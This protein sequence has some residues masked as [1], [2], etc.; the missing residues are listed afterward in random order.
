MGHMALRRS[1][2]FLM[3]AR[4]LVVVGRVIGVSCGSGS[5]MLSEYSSEE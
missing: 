1:D 4:S 2:E 5:S 3:E